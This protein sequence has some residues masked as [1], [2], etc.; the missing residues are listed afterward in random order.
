MQHR[1]ERSREV[2][3]KW[4]KSETLHKRT[5]LVDTRLCCFALPSVLASSN[6]SKKKNHPLVSS[7]TQ[8]GQGQHGVLVSTRPLD[9]ELG[10][11]AYE[12]F[13]GNAQRAVGDYAK[14]GF[15]RELCDA[16]RN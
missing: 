3:G 4:E 1:T 5:I 8:P 11:D 12:I 15:A 2:L 7:V 6:P 10:S 16:A 13:L 14:K 9:K